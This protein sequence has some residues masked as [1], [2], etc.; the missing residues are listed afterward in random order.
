MGLATRGHLLPWL[1]NRCICSSYWCT[2]RRTK[3]LLVVAAGRPLRTASTSC[4]R[5]ICPKS[6]RR[7]RSLFLRLRWKRSSRTVT[8][9]YSSII[10]LSEIPEH[11]YNRLDPRK[12]RPEA[13]RP[14]TAALRASAATE[15]KACI[16]EFHDLLY[17][18]HAPHSGSDRSLARK[19]LAKAPAQQLAPIPLDLPYPPPA[20]SSCRAKPPP[21]LPLSQTA[22]R[23]LQPQPRPRRSRWRRVSV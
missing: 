1:I 12:S 21:R 18:S 16:N 6:I 13:H 2:I 5:W 14:I 10:F 19:H 23:P 22:E 4:R 20:R 7:L 17:R 3:S 8:L 9:E 11:Y 15:Y